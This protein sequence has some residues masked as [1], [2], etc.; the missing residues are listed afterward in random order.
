LKLKP[1]Q[2]TV[3]LQQHGLAPLYLL[4]GDEPLQM[5]EST[6]K[7]RTFARAQGFNE[8]RVFTAEKDFDWNNLDQQ[9]NSLSLFAN[10]RLL[11]VHLGHK[12]PDDVGST[13]LINYAKHPP[14]DTLLLLTADKLDPSKQKT[15]WLTTLDDYGVI[16]PIWP[17]ETS[18][19]PEWIA[20][21]MKAQGLQVSSD[22]V[23]IIA[24]RSEGHLLA[25]AQ[26]IEKLYLLYGSASLDTTHVLDAV[27]D[28]ARFSVFEWVDSVL[29]GDIT[30][31]VRQLYSLQAENLE[32]VSIIGVLNREI[33][34]LC[35]IAYA[36]QTGHAQEQLFKTYRIWQNR[37]NVVISALKRHTLNNW[38]RFLQQSVHIERIV[39]GAEQGNSWDEL[40]HLSLQIAGITLFNPSSF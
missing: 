24:E 33:R 12:L 32:L 3:H 27:A 13:V 18:R 37:R 20:Q 14:A 10:K 17:I 9:I 39:K 15:K 35:H 8:R 38:W 40:L 23:N 2:L 16:I 5:M 28:N 25:C 29:A 11:E 36:L 1:T 19:L 21:R 6:D 26:E 22:A 34:N 4:T 31:S 7:V 30:R